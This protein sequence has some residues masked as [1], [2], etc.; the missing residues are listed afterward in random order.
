M[1]IQRRG[2]RFQRGTGCYTCASCGK[3]TR[4][5]GRGDNENVGMCAHCYDRAEDENGLSDESITQAEF[6]A[7]WYG[8]PMGQPPKK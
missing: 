1:N 2:N 6:D 3:K 8:V 7:R 4:S 5:T